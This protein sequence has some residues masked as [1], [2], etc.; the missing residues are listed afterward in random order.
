MTSKKNN[1]KTGFYETLE[2]ISSISQNTQEN[3]SMKNI[4][5]KIVEII[6][7]MNINIAKNGENN[8]IRE[9]I[10]WLNLL[11]KYP[12]YDHLEN[13]LLFDDFLNEKDVKN[14]TIVINTKFQLIYK[15]NIR[16]LIA[17]M[18]CYSRELPEFKFNFENNPYKKLYNDNIII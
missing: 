5:L 16:K 9:K 6:Q 8:E 3:N 14:L 1:E 4:R 17:L 2:D 12:Y 7:K 11:Y 13:Y 18:L 10:K 15:A